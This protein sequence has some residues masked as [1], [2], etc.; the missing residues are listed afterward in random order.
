MKRMTI[1]VVFLIACSSIAQV[2]IRDVS[3]VLDIYTPVSFVVENK[4]MELDENGN[5]R[6]GLLTTRFDIAQYIYRTIKNF[7]LDE[8]SKKFS[9]LEETQKEVSAKMS[10]IEAAY[11]TYDQRLRELETATVNLQ[12]QLDKLSQE[13]FAQVQKQ[14]LDYIKSQENQLAKIDA[15]TA[16]LD[17]V[18]KLNSELFK[19]MQAQQSDLNNVL[20]EQVSIKNQI[21]SLSQQLSALKSSVESLAKKLDQTSAELASLKDSTKNEFAAFTSLID[22]KISSSE[23]RLNVTLKSLQNE[24]ALQKKELTDRIEESNRL[25]LQ[26]QDLQ[27]R[28]TTLE[29][30]ASKQQI[31]E[32]KDQIDGLAEKTSKIEQ[33]LRNLESNL[34]SLDLSRLQRRIEELEAKNKSLESNLNMAYIVGAAGIAIGLLA[35][36]L[37]L[38]GK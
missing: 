8:L 36:I 10:G 3:P 33:E 28:L 21:L 9:A 11:R 14:L 16:R 37:G 29:S 13:L 2:N 22:Q 25:K 27:K 20:N 19:Q 24:L 7:Q 34:A 18:E 17:A 12:S 38:G 15:L 26:I 23:N 4:I 1:L 6:G 30:F 32:L 31:Q 35:I 5:F